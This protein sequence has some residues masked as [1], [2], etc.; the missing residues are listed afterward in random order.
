MRLAPEESASQMK[1]PMP[2]M[3]PGKRQKMERDKIEEI[4]ENAL[5]FGQLKKEG[6]GAN[7]CIYSI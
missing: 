7:A 5:S 1:L 4:V 6:L 2:T 3:R